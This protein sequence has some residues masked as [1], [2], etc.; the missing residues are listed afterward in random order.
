MNS[1]NLTNPTGNLLC[2]GGVARSLKLDFICDVVTQYR[3]CLSR[4]V[5]KTKFSVATASTR[6]RLAHNSPPTAIV[7]A[8][9]MFLLWPGQSDRYTGDL[10]VK[11]CLVVRLPMGT[12]GYDC[13]P[14]IL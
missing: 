10:C 6:L 5:M 13:L 3:P 2:W 14:H 4:T 1:S 12:F 7:Q 8:K 9:V 11:P